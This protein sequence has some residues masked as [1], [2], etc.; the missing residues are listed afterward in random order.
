MEG[1]LEVFEELKDQQN[2]LSGQEK[3]LKKLTAGA[4]LLQAECM[5]KWQEKMVMHPSLTQ[6][7]GKNS[8]SEHRTC[9]S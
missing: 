7:L 1:D 6:E 9:S 4:I 8:E 2:P 3:K 5:T